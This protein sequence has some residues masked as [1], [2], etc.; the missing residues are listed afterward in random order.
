MSANAD[1][2]ILPK[3]ELAFFS[4]SVASQGWDHITL[5]PTAMSSSASPLA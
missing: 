5:G 1:Q 2:K 4:I 3:T